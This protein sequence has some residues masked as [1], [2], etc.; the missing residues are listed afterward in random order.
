MKEY[1]EMTSYQQ[2][3]MDNFLSEYEVRKGNGL[4]G[5][6]VASFKPFHGRSGEKSLLGTNAAQNGSGTLSE[7]S[8]KRHIEIPQE[9]LDLNERMGDRLKDVPKRVR[10]LFLSLMRHAVDNRDGRH[11]VYTVCPGDNKEEIFR[12]CGWVNKVALYRGLKILCECFVIR[13]IEFGKYEFAPRY[14][15]LV[16]E[17]RKLKA[18]EAE[19]KGILPVE[20]KQDRED[21]TDGPAESPLVIGGDD[22]SAVDAE[23]EVMDSKG[24]QGIPQK[25]S[26]GFPGVPEQLQPLLSTLHRLSRDG[27]E[28]DIGDAKEPFLGYKDKAT[29][30]CGLN[31]LRGCGAIQVV[32]W[33]KFLLR[34]AP[35]EPPADDACSSAGSSVSEETPVSKED[36]ISN[37]VLSGSHESAE[38]QALV[39]KEMPG[40]PKAELGQMEATAEKNVQFIPGRWKALYQGLCR[41]IGSNGLVHTGG[42]AASELAIECGW[43]S[44]SS[45]FVGLRALCGCGAIEKI[46][47]GIYRIAA[48]SQNVYVPQEKASISEETLM[49]SEEAQVPTDNS[50]PALHETSRKEDTSHSG[51]KLVEGEG[52][53]AVP[54]RWKKLML[55]LFHQAENGRVNTGG[56]AANEIARECGWT[57][58]VSIYEG[59]RELCSCGAIKK[60]GKGKYQIMVSPE[61]IARQSALENGKYQPNPHVLRFEDSPKNGSS[62][63]SGSTKRNVRG[64][65]TIPRKGRFQQQ[66]STSTPQEVEFKQSVLAALKKYR[67]E[68]G[69]GCY[70][71]LAKNAGVS[72]DCIR[73]IMDSGKVSYSIWK[74][75]GR[76]LGVGE[77]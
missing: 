64:S 38:T 42:S 48:H 19:E 28:V 59:L 11:T 51:E 16:E 33:G 72:V 17:V 68:K 4:V 66:G 8:G 37:E 43:T 75:I 61:V 73:T 76:E 49:P 70:N 63:T 47:N 69:L 18:E 9:M 46:E 45:V 53:I 1:Q 74:K 7:K 57:N 15:S 10:I 22:E 23:S 44:K 5:G 54:E 21:I 65:G 31:A 25:T 6:R 62:D 39:P 3:Q 12:E 60:L 32:G 50:A 14:R 30:Y 29:L 40:E 34:D 77:G 20:S 71:A 58:K 2:S 56:S 55:A 36:R 52:T 27:K 24:V 67:A 41:K 13:K 35:I 26:E